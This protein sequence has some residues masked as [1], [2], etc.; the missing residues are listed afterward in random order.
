MRGEFWTVNSRSAESVLR[1]VQNPLGCA[2]RFAEWR[3]KLRHFHNACLAALQGFE[4]V[5]AIF[6]L[7]ANRNQ[8]SANVLQRPSEKRQMQN[9][10]NRE[11]YGISPVSVRMGTCKSRSPI[12][13]QLYEFAS[14]AVPDLDGVRRVCF[15]VFQVAKRE[16]CFMRCCQNDFGRVARIKRFLPP[17]RTQA[18]LVA[19]LQ[20]G[21]AKL[22]IRRRQVVS[23][24]FGEGQELGGED[25]ANCVR[26]HVFRARI[27]AAIAEKAGHWR[28]AAG[29]QLTAEHVFGLRNADHAVCRGNA[30]HNGPYFIDVCG[31]NEPPSGCHA[32]GS[33]WACRH[34][35]ETWPLP[36]VAM[37]RKGS[38]K[39]PRKAAEPL[40]G[41]GVWYNVR[42]TFQT[43]VCRQPDRHCSD[44]RGQW[45]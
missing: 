44:L 23:C 22:Q 34:S 40:A 13:A 4:L 31:A 39:P 12:R 42:R 32:H 21:E 24:G 35:R 8:V 10:L 2:A 17:W 30:D 45:R 18:P 16:A 29:C 3:C 33:A 20:T 36:T 15:Q 43:L 41:S 14:G 9:P 1:F 7:A 26:P 19:G 27:A 11:V 28:R 25:D 37:A 6:T 38:N 5:N